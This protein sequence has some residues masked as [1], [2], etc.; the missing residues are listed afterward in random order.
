[1][2]I[3]TLPAPLS[4]RNYKWEA[5]LPNRVFP[6]DLPEEIWTF[7][8]DY[9]SGLAGEGVE[10]LFSDLFPGISNRARTG[11]RQALM[12]ALL[13][14]VQCSRATT[15]RQSIGFLHER[16]TRSFKEPARYKVCDYGKRPFT[17]ALDTLAKAGLVKCHKGFRDKEAPL[18]VSSLWLPGTQLNEWL[19]ACGELSV[20][21]FRPVRETLIL[22]DGSRVPLDYQ[23]GEETRAMR[24][25]IEAA[26]ALREHLE[27][28][29]VPLVDDRQYVE[30]DARTTI[31]GASLRC[32]RVFR[33]DFRSGGRFYCG[34]QGLRKAERATIQVNGKSTI[35][36][37]Y[38]SLHPRLLYNAEGLAAPD[39]CY[40]SN[41]RSRDLTKLISLLCIN[42]DSKKQAERAL[43]SNWPM[44]SEEASFHL[45]GYLAEHPAI[46]HRLF[47]SGWKRLQYLDSQ[48]VDKVLAAG[49][50]RDIAILPVH[51]SFIVD[52]QWAPW[53]KDKVGQAYRDITGFEGVIDW[54]P[55]PDMSEF[56]WLD[57]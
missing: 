11:Q 29:Y 51:D 12:A 4:R 20:I 36:L 57:R 2:D 33:E 43:R 14:L 34:A 3:L 10:R 32:H 30:A 56:D 18:G 8:P 13:A 24:D 23:D 9:G 21:T 48:L 1:V 49:C 35:E 17:E 55:M 50:Y 26:N 6:G 41:S 47:Q 40:A 54:E 46:A 5:V 31:H 16:T 39:D 42:C 52:T 25:R 7:S 22:R 37:D 28:T 27:W 15:G 45:D 19:A 44:N 53:L 38:K